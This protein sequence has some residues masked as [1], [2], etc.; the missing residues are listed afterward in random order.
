MKH[1]EV[2][3]PDLSR[4][5]VLYQADLDGLKLLRRGL[6]RDVFDLGQHVLI[7]ATDRQSVSGVNMASPVPLKGR[8]LTEMCAFWFEQ[9]RHLIPNH[10]VTKDVDEMK[11]HGHDLTP[12][13]DQIEGR[14]I[15]ARKAD[16]LPVA[17]V[18]RGYLYGSGWR[19]YKKAK[20]LCGQPLPRNLRVGSRLPVPL[21]TPATQ[22]PEG[23]RVENIGWDLMVDM[24]GRQVAE[25]MRE[26]SAAVYKFAAA[27]CLEREVI[28]AD[29]KLEFG[30]VD[31]EV[32]LIDELITPDSSRLWPN[33]AYT[34]GRHQLAFDKQ[35]I[36]DYLDAAGWDAS[37]PGPELPPKVVQKISEK[38]FAAFR[39]LLGRD[40]L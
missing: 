24:L 14:S 2:S 23:G 11:D 37:Q 16:V 25:T 33:D 8:V 34:P 5:P 38:Y 36:R 1:I 19:E 39:Q 12:Y 29:T 35:F 21:F 15:L 40:E 30:L 3:L 22:K 17:C 32:L 13:R 9:T 27:Y 26:A 31:G 18:M 28:L 10:Y 6:V 20:S 4:Y 7:V